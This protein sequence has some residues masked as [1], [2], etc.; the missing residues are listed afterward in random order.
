M[1]DGIEHGGRRGT[2]LVAAATV[3]LLVMGLALITIGVRGTAGPPQPASDAAAPPS[4]STSSTSASQSTSTRSKQKSTAAP[5]AADAPDAE[6]VDFGLVL[7]DSEPVALDIPS[8]GVHS[9]NIVDLALA[10]DGTMEVPTDASAP[11][12]FTP[13][14][15]PGQFGP[16]VIAG[17]VD[18]DEGPAVFYRLGELRGG[19]RV[20]VT[21]ADGTVAT[22]VI[23]R[24]GLFDKA[25]FPTHEV[26][27][28]TTGRAEL[29]LI[30]CGGTYDEDNGY[31]GNVVAFGH[32]VATG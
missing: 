18:S 24:V 16:S 17:H 23:D 25:S 26:Y 31:L 22:F 19:E 3:A 9:S 4:S 2:Y 29:R 10:E 8:I 5:D 11:G 21:R 1:T 30:T 12:W 7:Q 28:D 15:S 32:L 27:G 6:A 14:P 13:G 20:K